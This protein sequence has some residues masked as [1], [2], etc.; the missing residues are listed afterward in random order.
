[1]PIR[2]PRTGLLLSAYVDEIKTGGK[3]N[4]LKPMSDK[5]MKQVDLEEPT[6]LLDQVFL[7]VHAA[8]M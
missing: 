5:L 7:G 1:M 4:N 8:R 6:L 2:A 3:K